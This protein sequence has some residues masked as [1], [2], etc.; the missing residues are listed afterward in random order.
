MRSAAAHA[1]LMVRTR[2]AWGTRS[3]AAAT[4]AC[5]GERVYVF[6]GSYGLLCYD[7]AGQK[8]WERPMGPFRDEYGA[9]SSPI[10]VDGKII[11]QEDHDLDSFLAALEQCMLG[12]GPKVM[13]GAGVAAAEKAYAAA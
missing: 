2:K 10:L 1:S 11:L 9:G 5:D 6:F 4:P 7:L 12:Q 8:L 3:P 13:P